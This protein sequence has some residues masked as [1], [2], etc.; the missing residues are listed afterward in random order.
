[1]LFRAETFCLGSCTTPVLLKLKCLAVDCMN[2]FLALYMQ[3]HLMLRVNFREVFKED[4]SEFNIPAW[5]QIRISVMLSTA[6][7]H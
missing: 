5:Q 6:T 1:M 3:P 7:C 2:S 4:L